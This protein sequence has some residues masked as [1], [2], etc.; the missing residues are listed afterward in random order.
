MAERIRVLV[1]RPIAEVWRAW[2]DPAKLAAWFGDSDGPLDRPGARRI[3]FGDGDFFATEVLEAAAPRAISLRWRLLGLGDL[4]RVT[5]RLAP[6]E[7]E[8]ATHVEV[9]DSGVAGPDGTSIAEGWRDFLAR[10]VRYCETGA[11]A[12]YG[13]SEAIAFAFARPGADR[14]LLDELTH[15]LRECAVE[16]GLASAVEQVTA[17]NGVDLVV[18]H[19]GAGRT[20]ASLRIVAP[21]R[22]VVEHTG[23]VRAA[24]ER[25]ERIGARRS[26]VGVWLAACAAVG[27]A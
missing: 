25:G 3:E 1:R 19:R 8:P 22:V 20:E 18:T 26:W 11:S 9:S 6:A 21:G 15:R 7:P 5:I 27:A 14:R 17:E 2:T 12:R 4:D 10:L 23:W 13:W 24:G 16:A